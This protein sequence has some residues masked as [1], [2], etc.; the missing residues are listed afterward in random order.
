MAPHRVMVEVPHVVVLL[1]DINSLGDMV[2]PQGP[3]PN[4]ICMEVRG[5]ELLQ[6]TVNSQDN[7]GL[8]TVNPQ[9]VR[10]T[11][12]HQPHRATVN[13]QVDK[14]VTIFMVN[15]HLNSSHRPGVKPLRD[16]GRLLDRPHPMVSNSQGA[17]EDISSLGDM[18]SSQE[19]L[20]GSRH[21]PQGSAL[22]SGD[23]FR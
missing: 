2:H 23:G 19:G 18:V 16:M 11:V 8:G 9:Q 6:D 20:V 7:Q 10:D 13:Q 22:N 21:L 1:V 12:N 5:L 4:N 3:H 14:G 17:M 15:L